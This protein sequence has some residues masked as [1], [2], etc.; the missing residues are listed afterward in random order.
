MIAV[1]KGDMKWLL[2]PSAHPDLQIGVLPFDYAQ[3][4]G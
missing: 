4:S 2:P 1:V 3:P